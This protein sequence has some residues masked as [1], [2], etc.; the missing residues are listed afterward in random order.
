MGHFKHQLFDGMNATGL[1]DIYVYEFNYI[2]FFHFAYSNISVLLLGLFKVGDGTLIALWSAVFAHR[3]ETNIMW[4]ICA[5]QIRLAG[6]HTNQA[7]CII[8]SITIVIDECKSY[9]FVFHLRYFVL[10][11]I[12][13]Q[14]H[15]THILCTSATDTRAAT[16]LR[17]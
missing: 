5:N 2:G 13:V 9:T 17:Q 14:K 10:P 8:I 7:A 1:Y 11:V 6:R 12:K 15:C 4:E 16:Y 3:H